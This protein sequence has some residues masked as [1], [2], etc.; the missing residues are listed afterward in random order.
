VTEGTGGWARNKEL[1]RVKLVR[2]AV[3]LFGERGFDNTT[4]DD[5]V[6][7]A[8]C[9]RRTFFRYF[10]TKEDVLLRGVADAMT[11]FR[12]FMAEPLTD[13]TRWEQI[14]IGAQTAVR[15]IVEPH[16][17]VEELTIASWL[18][19]PAIARRFSVF[20]T[21]LEQIMARAL[22]E[23]R[24]VD[25]DRDLPVQLTARATVAACTAAIHVYVHAH[26]DLERLFEDV[27]A[28]LEGVQVIELATR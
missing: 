7:T 22:A 10:T 25:P 26:T 3:R 6:A 21:E 4:V 9:S 19:E 24:G 14:R 20:L 1:T 28:L 27:F 18:S 23:E 5:L 12:A 17:G 11:E 13:L 2:A 15:R 16:S 8:G